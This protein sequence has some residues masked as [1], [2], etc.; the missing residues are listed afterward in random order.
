[1][2]K[3]KSAKL[4]EKQKRARRKKMIAKKMPIQVFAN[5]EEREF[6]RL[7]DKMSDRMFQYTKDGDDERAAICENKLELFM[8]MFF[9]EEDIFKTEGAEAAF[10]WFEAWTLRLKA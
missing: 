6:N 4:R 10:K 7:Y 8:D 9:D 2:A 1:V 3:T 5:D